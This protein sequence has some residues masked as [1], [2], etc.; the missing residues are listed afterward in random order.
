MS[1]RPTDAARVFQINRSKGGV[2]KLPVMRA[3]ISP[4]GV[5]GDRQ[6]NLRV[7]GG[8]NRAVC[9]YSLELIQELQ[10]DG[11]S[12]HPGSIGENITLSG[13]DLAALGP[14]DA[15]QLG[16]DVV[17]EITDYAHPCQNIAASF[18][19]GKITVVSQKVRPGKSRLYARVLQS[20]DVQAGDPVR[21]L[22][23][24]AAQPM[25]KESAQAEVT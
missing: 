22:G 7:H 21:L 3:R 5:E 19:D 12:I 16:D 8:P 15:L 4:E 13:V 2:P 14:G 9:L 23:R 10:A 18:R 24:L 6:R 20:G 11:H 17:I 1:T 25:A